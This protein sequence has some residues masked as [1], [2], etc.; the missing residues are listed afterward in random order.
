MT[1]FRFTLLLTIAACFGATV[2]SQSANK[3]AEA[4]LR[5]LDVAAAKAVLEK[6]EK[7]IARYFTKESVTNNPRNG[8]TRGSDGVIEAVRTNLVNYHSFTRALESV[9]VI[10]TTAVTMGNETVV[11]KGPDGGAGRTVQRRYTNVWMKRGKTWQIVA[12]HAN[13]ICE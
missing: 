4:E 6:D 2:Y 5:V 7:A 13:V 9:Q 1:T 10:G 12:R 11:M 3:T 8:L